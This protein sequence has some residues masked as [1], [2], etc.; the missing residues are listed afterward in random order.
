MKQ[1]A[2][3]PPGLGSQALT[4]YRKEL[5]D[6]CRDHRTLWVML[7]SSVL[8]APLMLW[9][10]SFWMAGLQARADQR[11]VWVVGMAHA[12]TLENFLA[13]QTYRIKEPP[14]EFEALLRRGKFHDPV[15]R[16]PPEFEA[17]LAQG[18][19]PLL[20]LITDSGNQQALAGIGRWGQLLAAFKSERATLA[21]A[22]RGV[23]P[24]LL[25]SVQWQEQDLASA[26]SRAASISAILPWIFIMAV[27]SG[28]MNAALDTTAGERERGSLEP[29]LMNPVSGLALAL[30]KWGA[31]WTLSS[32]VAL[33]SCA[34]FI[35]AQLLFKGDVLRSLIQF[36]PAQVA[37]SVGIL[38]PLAACV[39][40][41]LMWVA[42]RCSS[43][44]EAQASTTIVVMLFTTLPLLSSLNIINPQGW[45]AVV[46]G[47]GQHALMGRVLKGETLSAWQWVA[48]W[49]VSF[50]LVSVCL[51]LIARRWKKSIG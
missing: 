16:V 50:V 46:P 25:E 6:A 1:G 28:A 11:E 29:L 32:A 19:A 4:V 40:A 12:P 38:L 33:L 45:A 8:L 36:G 23:S 51:L 43:V 30:G 15:L 21:L 34:S 41:L 22:L 31:V 42:I 37:L 35:P 13:R 20:T 10:L 9:A 27:L 17:D 49:G 14:K 3:H 26:F 18:K 7:V 5:R 24:G 44:K 48:P 2:K 47:L 39:S